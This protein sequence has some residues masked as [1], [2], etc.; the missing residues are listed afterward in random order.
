MILVLIVIAIAISNIYFYN[1]IVN[2]K[3]S[4]NGQDKALQKAQILNADFKNS[5]YQILD[6][7]NLTELAA[8]LVLVKDS[9]PR[10][11]EFGTPVAA[12]K[13]LSP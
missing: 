3:Y 4:L 1:S 6:S 5:L 11:L 13:S 7:R 8:K 9:K 10:Y 12:S 2:L